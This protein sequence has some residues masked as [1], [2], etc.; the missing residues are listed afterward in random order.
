MAKVFLFLGT[1][2]GRLAEHSHAL[3]PLG[4]YLLF[5]SVPRGFR[6]MLSRFMRPEPGS[7]LAACDQRRHMTVAHGFK[8]SQNKMG[9]IGPGNTASLHAGKIGMN[10]IAAG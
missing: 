3:C 6:H 5:R 1:P 4:T 8:L 9:H 10:G 7:A 2:T